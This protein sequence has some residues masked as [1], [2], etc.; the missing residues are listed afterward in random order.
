[1]IVSILH[2]EFVQRDD[3]TIERMHAQ[4]DTIISKNSSFYWLNLTT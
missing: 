2:Y 3:K 1:M 4:C